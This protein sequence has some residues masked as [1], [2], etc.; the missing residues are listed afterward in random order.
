MTLGKH[1]RQLGPAQL[2][3]IGYVHQEGQLIPW[4]RVGQLIDYVKA[5]YANWNDR[6]EAEYIGRFHVR[7]EARVGSLSPGERQKVAILLAIGFEP[8]LLLLDEPAS[9]LDPLA[10]ARFLDLLLK[11]IQTQG[12]SIVVSS[13]ILSDIEKVV[14]HLVIIDSGR[15]LRDSPLDELQ[16]KYL[17]VKLTSVKG[18]IPEEPAVGTVLESAGDTYERVFVFKDTSEAALKQW[19]HEIGCDVERL[20]LD[21]DDIYRL[22]FAEGTAE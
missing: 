7:S 19:A 17:S 3:R 14:D 21:L 20:L 4:M 5:Y 10:R 22:I 13:H 2:A 18:G 12:R 16:E 9:A 11:M 15:I 1:A 8:E 6:L